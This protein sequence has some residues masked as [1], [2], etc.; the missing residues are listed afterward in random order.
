MS[1]KK[2]KPIKLQLNHLKANLSN[3]KIVICLNKMVVM[4]F[5]M[6]GMRH[7]LKKMKSNFKINFKQTLNP[8][9]MNSFK[10]HKISM[11]IFKINVKNN[12]MITY[13]K[14]FNTREEK[15]PLNLKIKRV[16]IQKLK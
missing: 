11:K 4:N 16:F 6:K 1:N 14:G 15:P 3:R 13:F 10:N 8:K 5:I 2:Q 9:M 7:F 12:S